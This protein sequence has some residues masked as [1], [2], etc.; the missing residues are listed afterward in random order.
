MAWRF[1]VDAHRQVPRQN[2]SDNQRS[3]HIQPPDVLGGIRRLLEDDPLVETSSFRVNFIAIRSFSDDIEISAYVFAANP[4]L[5]YEAQESLLVKILGIVES[6]G[7][8]FSLPTQ[9]TR[10]VT[11][12]RPT[13]PAP[14]SAPSAPAKDSPAARG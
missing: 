12:D 4:V 3:E 1:I 9:V 14:A 7:A 13:A 5:F 8:E 11:A 2:G 10:I 6:V